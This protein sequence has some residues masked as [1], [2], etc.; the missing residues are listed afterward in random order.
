MSSPASSA[1]L[2]KW[3]M[4]L[5]AVGASGAATVATDAG[6]VPE[7]QRFGAIGILAGLLIVALVYMAHRNEQKDSLIVKMHEAHVV[8]MK[9]HSDAL[10]DE[11]KSANESRAENTAA[12]RSLT[13]AVNRRM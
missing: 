6:P 13:E 12:L 1:T 5:I 11:I 4:G 7:L 2:Y 8:A 9:E 3:V 10:V